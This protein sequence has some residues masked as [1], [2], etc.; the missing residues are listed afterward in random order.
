MAGHKRMPKGGHAAPVLAEGSYL[1]RCVPAM[2]N[3]AIIVDRV[4][5]R[6]IM[7]GPQPRTF[8]EAVLRAIGALRSKQPFWALRDVSFA[9]NAGEAVAIV[10]HNG[11]GKSTL[12]RLICGLSRPTS[13]HAAARGRVAALLELGAGFHPDLTGRQNLQVSATISGL[14]RPEVAA[15]FDEIV[16]FAEIAEFIDQPL[17]MYSSGMRMRLGFAVA[18]HVDPTILIVDE[19]LAVG[20]AGFREKCLDRIE[21]FR[22][23][24]KTLLLVSHDL[25]TVQRFC[26]RTIW[27]QSGAIIAD[28]PSEEVVDAYRRQNGAPPDPY[29]EEAL[30]YANRAI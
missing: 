1:R 20:D 28:G 17:R 15:R 2:D 27:L 8:Q 3:Q 22:R 18:I 16:S 25:E 10:G 30:A 26:P 4:S 19:A 12:L 14:S 9:V 29:F 21:I 11:A 23:Q 6:Y 7:R 13:G 24:G 5:K